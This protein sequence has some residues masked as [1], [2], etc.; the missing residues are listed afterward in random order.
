MLRRSDMKDKS[1]TLKQPFNKFLRAKHYWEDTI[2]PALISHSWLLLLLSRSVHDISP[3]LRHASCLSLLH[4]ISLSLRVVQVGGCPHGD[5]AKRGSKAGSRLCRLQQAGPRTLL[6]VTDCVTLWW[7]ICGS[8][9]FTRSP[10]YS[11][12]GRG[13]FV[14]YL[15][16][17]IDCFFQRI[18]VL[19]LFIRALQTLERTP[20]LASLCI[21]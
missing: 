9:R 1:N 15:H 12:I 3:L 6:L 7:E 5:R 19:E 14:P 18:V 8:F 20:D 2:N 11:I 13:R 17:Q 10:P 16:V 4:Q 21:C